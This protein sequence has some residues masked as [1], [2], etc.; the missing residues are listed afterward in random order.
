MSDDGLLLYG[1]DG[2]A[3]GPP[4]NWFDDDFYR[5]DKTGTG[6]QP[7]IIADFR[8]NRYAIDSGGGLAS[9]S[10]T[11]V[12]ERYLGTRG[13]LWDANGDPVAHP[14]SDDPMVQYYDPE[15][16][17]GFGKGGSKTRWMKGVSTAGTT[18]EAL[19]GYASAPFGQI[20][21]NWT[22]QGSATKNASEAT[23][24]GVFDDAAT[25]ESGG[26]ASAD[27]VNAPAASS[28]IADNG[29]FYFDVY[30]KAGS[31][32]NVRIILSDGTNSTIW[33]GTIGSITTSGAGTGMA[34]NTTSPISS[35]GW[36]EVDMDG[37]GNYRFRAYMQNT[38]GS[39]KTYTIGIGPD[40]ASTGQGVIVYGCQLISLAN[41]TA[42]DNAN[43]FFNLGGS[44]FAHQ[45]HD[46]FTPAIDTLFGAAHTVSVRQVGNANNTL[47]W[48]HWAGGVQGYWPFTSSSLH[49]AFFSNNG[50]SL[51]VNYTGTTIPTIWQ[52][53]G[54]CYSID[55]GNLHVS[56]NG[57]AASSDTSGTAAFHSTGD[58]Y[59]AGLHAVDEIIIWDIA[60]SATNVALH[61]DD[62]DSAT[63]RPA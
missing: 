54:L 33:N 44:G 9:G 47:Q 37:S 26:S 40:S 46:N 8:N 14:V 51:S 15:S 31:S 39:A 60:L 48:I 4:S 1:V 57:D 2:A 53:G 50:G 56:A 19:I 49:R 38:S 13:M 23:A 25:V 21:T 22:L 7:I 10:I 61:S 24:W 58:T 34:F 42:Q 45:D 32:G 43:V 11:D 59:L 20:G 52:S 29:Y 18:N 41:A 16:A 30:Y 17:G 62:Y 55:S 3:A 27:Y 35:P 6:T 5:S 63:G 28:T 36:K 12:L